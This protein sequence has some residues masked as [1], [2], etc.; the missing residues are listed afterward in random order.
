M[1]QRTVKAK[2]IVQDIRSGMDRAALTEKHHIS[3]GE[4]A[5][6]LKKL[7]ELRALAPSE[8]G[9]IESQAGGAPDHVF[10]CP[11]CGTTDAADLDE[12]PNCGAM[13]AK[14]EAEMM[15]EEVAAPDRQ[16][17]GQPAGPDEKKLSSR[18]AGNPRSGSFSG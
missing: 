2:E 6:L 14:I 12:C 3:A 10:E 16:I 18:L 8:V 11:E 5:Q 9:G 4:L 15:E 13:V 17:V 7:V 1:A